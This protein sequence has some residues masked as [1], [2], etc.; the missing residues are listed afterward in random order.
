MSY[1]KGPW[2]IW[3][4]P[5]FVG[6]GEDLC[7]GAGDTWLANM[8]HRMRPNDDPFPMDGWLQVSE[9]DIATIDS[10]TITAEQ[11]DN[12]RLIAAAPALLEAAQQV[13]DTRGSILSSSLAEAFAVLLAAVEQA[14]GEDG[15]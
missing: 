2:R 15:S 4:G 5:Q 11:E 12:A 7:I 10:S 13:L 6:G 9:C 1:T 14:T 8:D 3:R